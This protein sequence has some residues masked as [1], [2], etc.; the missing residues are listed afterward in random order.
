VPF[1]AVNITPLEKAKAAGCD[2]FATR[3]VELP[4]LLEKNQPAARGELDR[5]RVNS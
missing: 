3:P 1:I 2:D 4:R 5:Q